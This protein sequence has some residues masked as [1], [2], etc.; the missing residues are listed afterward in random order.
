V[1]EPPPVPPS[2]DPRQRF[3]HLEIG[4][5]TDLCRQFD[6]AIS[7]GDTGDAATFADGVAAQRVMDRIR[8]VGQGRSHR[9]GG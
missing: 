1:F 8:E 4:P 9:P 7:T 6:I 2:D 3:T 5:F